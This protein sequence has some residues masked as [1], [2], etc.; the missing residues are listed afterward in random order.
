MKNIQEILESTKYYKFFKGSIEDLSKRWLEPH[1]YFHTL[2]HLNRIVNQIVADRNKFTK[3]EYDVL[4][5]AAVY[6][7]IVYL[8]REDFLNVRESIEKFEEDF[9]EMPYLVRDLIVD[10]IESTNRHDFENGR[11]I[12]RI[13][14]S[15]DM[16]GIL[17]GDLK[18]LIE[19]GDNVAKEYHLEPEDYKRRRIEFLEKYKEYN[20]HIQECIDYL[21]L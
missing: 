19:D 14:N 13:F 21:K 8:P 9:P 15:Y 1:R 20:P 4:L 3:L 16:V 6:H 17:K 18:T 12:N 7:D 10:A 2:D 11:K 5:I